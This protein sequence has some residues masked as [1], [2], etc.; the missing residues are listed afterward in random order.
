MKKGQAVFPHDA[1]PVPGFDAGCFQTGGQ[2]IHLGFE[3][4]PKVTVVP[5]SASNQADRSR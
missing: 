4:S 2:L 5:L 3:L 1:N